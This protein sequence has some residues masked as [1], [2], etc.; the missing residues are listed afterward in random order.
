MAEMN[1]LLE[2]TEGQCSALS[3]ELDTTV[4]SIDEMT[5]KAS[6]LCEGALRVGGQIRARLQALSARLEAAESAIENARAEAVTD[7]DALAEQAETVRTDVGDLLTRVQ[8]GL[9]ELEQQE[10]QLDEGVQEGMGAIGT[11]FSDLGSRVTEAQEAIGTELQEAGQRIAAFGEAINTARTDLAEKQQAWSD[12]LDTFEQTAQEKTREWVAA[13]QG[14]LADQTTAMVDLANRMLVKHNDTMESMK[15]LFE[16]Q[17]A[18]GAG[19]RPSSRCRTAWSGWGP[20]P[21]QRSGELTA[22][23]EESLQRVRAA[24]PGLEEIRG[25]FQQSGRLG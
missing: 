24:L 11:D 7:L 13:L 15:S 2:E 14:V 3:D 23:A 21:S 20:R 9:T 12:A 6:E 8:D 19:R 25:V 4:A 5:G 10:T 16:A 17:A 22:K 1:D 18:P